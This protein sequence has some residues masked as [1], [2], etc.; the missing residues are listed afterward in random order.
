M[1]PFY[2]NCDKIL[3]NNFVPYREEG[4]Y[5]KATR[6]TVIAVLDV[7]AE[8]YQVTLENVGEAELTGGE[9][10]KVAIWIYMLIFLAMAVVV[11]L[12]TSGGSGGSY[13]GGGYHGGFSGGHSGGSFGGGRSGGGGASR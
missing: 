9:E 7:I 12:G 8:E 10:N 11:C 1:L 13:G 2:V 5:T 3:D 4:D 6:N